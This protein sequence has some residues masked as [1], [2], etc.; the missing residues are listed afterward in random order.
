MAEYQM[1]DLSSGVQL[2][3]FEM[4]YESDH[5]ELFAEVCSEIQSHVG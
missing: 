4:N 5:P 3:Q 1:L 2:L